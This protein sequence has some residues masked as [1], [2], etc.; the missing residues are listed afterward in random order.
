MVQKWL[1]IAQNDDIN[2]SFSLFESDDLK[3]VQLKVNL[4]E[5][6]GT[7]MALP[8]EGIVRYLLRDLPQLIRSDFM[9]N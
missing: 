6:G 9:S 4:L 7:V 1:I 5:D 2:I 8:I 3:N